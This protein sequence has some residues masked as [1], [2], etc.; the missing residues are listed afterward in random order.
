MSLDERG[1]ANLGPLLEPGELAG[2]RAALDG[3]ARDATPSAYGLL[4]NNL[5][6]VLP[7]FA[8]LVRDGRIAGR[9]QRLLGVDS[10]QLFQDNLV[11]KLPGNPTEIQWHQ[12]FSYWPLDRPA[13]LTTWLALDDADEER[14]A[15]AF[16]PGSH[17]WGE[18]APADFIRGT[19]QPSNP[20]LLPLDP[21]GRAVEPALARAGELI[22]HHPLVWHRS[23]PNRSAQPRRA[24]TATW[25][26]P[27][28][29]WAT[30][31]APHPF[32]W[33]LRPADGAP[34]QGPT[35]PVL[36]PSELEGR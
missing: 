24:W 2:L 35:F 4:H 11:W 30:E 6:L 31:H 25:V 17:R 28:V 15:M 32:L 22:V 19:G 29:R 26:L 34:L 12:D 27:E 18:R 20:N 13:G 23:G 21:D 16:V 14:G 7:A 9:V 8:A 10:V 5:W 1:W 3:W 36:G 33:S